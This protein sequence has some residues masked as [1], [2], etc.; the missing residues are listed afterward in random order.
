[1]SVG[2]TVI[3]SCAASL[4]KFIDNVR[5]LGFRNTIFQSKIIL[6]SANCL[7]NN[8]KLTKFQTFTNTSVQSIFGDAENIP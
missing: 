2:F 6:E 4:L 5:L 8:L 7:K 1:M 3:G